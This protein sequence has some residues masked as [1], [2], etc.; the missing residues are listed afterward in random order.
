[1]EEESKV[2]KVLKVIGKGIITVIVGIFS[3]FIGFFA[4]EL[5]SKK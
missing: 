5:F 1:M 4:P 3:C 2:L